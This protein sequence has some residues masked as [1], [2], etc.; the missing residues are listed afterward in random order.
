M[1]SGHG[2]AQGQGSLANAQSTLVADGALINVSA[3]TSGDA[4]NAVVWSN[5]RTDFAGSIW[6]TGGS[7]SGSGGFVEMSGHDVL[8]FTG[9]VDLRATSGTQGRGCQSDRNSSAID[10]VIAAKA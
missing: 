2:D 5:Q 10:A 6:A 9:T 1:F 3:L 7:Q 8:N 4:G